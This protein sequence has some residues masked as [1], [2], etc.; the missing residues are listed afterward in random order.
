MALP[1]SSLDAE[2]HTK[3]I[4]NVRI[5]CS[6][7]PFSGTMPVHRNTYIRTFIREPLGKSISHHQVTPNG[8]VNDETKQV[9]PQI[10]PDWANNVYNC[11]IHS[12][13][14]RYCLCKPSSSQGCPGK[15]RP[16]NG[17]V[18][19]ARRRAE[20]RAGRRWA[21]QGADISVALEANSPSGPPARCKEKPG[22]IFAR[23]NKGNPM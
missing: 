15:T 7:K 8:C 1:S 9:F 3:L 21:K 4:N 12:E 5:I 6:C 23:T 22:R 16:H 17:R 11:R 10:H 2:T 19:S 20:G 18:G 13:S 14:A